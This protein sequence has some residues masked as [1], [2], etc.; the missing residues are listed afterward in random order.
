MTERRIVESETITEDSVEHRETLRK[1][2]AGR[3]AR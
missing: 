3:P 1:D 2:Y